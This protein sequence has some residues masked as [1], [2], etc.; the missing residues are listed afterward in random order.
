MSTA[1]RLAIPDKVDAM[2]CICAAQP[3][4]IPC[5]AVTNVS[6]VMRLGIAIPGKVGAF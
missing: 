6:F 5:P 3:Y 1:W 4:F 2:T